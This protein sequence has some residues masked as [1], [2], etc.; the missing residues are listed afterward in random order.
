MNEKVTPGPRGIPVLGNMPQLAANPAEYLLK[1][2]T[3]YGGMVYFRMIGRDF[4]LVAQPDYIQEV[5]VN[6]RDKFH[7][8]DI[9][10]EIM[11]KFLG[12]G[13]L[14]SEGN[15]HKRQRKLVQPAFH[16]NRIQAYA[17]TIV[18]YTRRMLDTWSDG[19]V[20]PV[21]EAMQQLTMEIV[22]KTLFDADVTGQAATIGEAMHVFQQI[23]KVDFRTQNIIPGWLPLPRNR[24]RIK[25]GQS[26]DGI[27][28]QII[29]ERRAA[30]EDRGDLMSMMLLS[31]DENGERMNDQELRDEAVTLFAAGHETTSNALTW[32]WYALSQNP[33]IEAKL[34]DEV[35][36]VLAGR[37]PTLA[38]LDKLPYTLMVLKESMRLYPPAWLLNSRKALEDVVI[39]G[40]HIPAGATVFVSP[41]AM[42][43]NPRYFDDP[44]R[45][46]PERFTP[47]REKAI[48]RY[49]YFPFGGGPRVCIGNSFALMEAHLIIAAVAQRYR[50]SLMPDQRVDIEPMITMAPRYG[51]RMRIEARTPANDRNGSITV[52]DNV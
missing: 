37:A 23:S 6:Q 25:A 51:M 20:Q 45:F 1:L 24:R 48:S 5:L 11:G 12:N 30:N 49:A 47:E 10:K 9:D 3:E 40:Y 38:D 18:N 50:L 43:R 21:A 8:A 15:Y 28:R 33:D 17:D 32:T 29:D 22:A 46:D 19:S 13:I 4:F 34:H 26:L 7:K 42:H 2:A 31:E 44:L 39:G 41:Y 35:D 14:L 52:F 36:R 27:V 16:T